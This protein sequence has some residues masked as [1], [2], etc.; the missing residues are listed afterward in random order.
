MLNSIAAWIKKNP[1]IVSWL[2][3]VASAAIAHFGLK[4]SPTALVGIV[5]TVMT[6]MHAWLHTK[7][8]S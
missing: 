2:A 4:V 7:T 5:G 8:K 6:I 3:T 1:A